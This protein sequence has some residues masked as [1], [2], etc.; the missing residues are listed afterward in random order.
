MTCRNRL[1]TTFTASAVPAAQAVQDDN[2]IISD[3]DYDMMM[4]QLISLEDKYPELKTPD[5]PSNRVG[6][7]ALSKFEQIRHDRVMMSLSNAFTAGELRDFDSKIKE[8]T[9]NP[10]YV[11]EFKID[12]LTLVLKYEKG[13]LISDRKIGRASCRERV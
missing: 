13:I 7:K 5:S 9:K 6:G 8:F 11:V 4:R 12:G 10:K 2:P 1:K 3:Y